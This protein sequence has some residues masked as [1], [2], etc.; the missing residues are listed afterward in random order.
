GVY[1]GV[2]GSAI[3][4]V[5]AASLDHLTLSPATAAVVAGA[6]Q[7]YA[8]EGFDLYGNDLGD[9]TPSSALSIAPDGTCTN[10]SCTATHWGAHTVAHGPLDY[11]ALTPVAATVVAGGTQVYAVEGFDQYG[12][13]R[14]SLVSSTFLS[15]SGGTCSG[16][17]CMGMTAGNQTVTASSGG[18]TAT[19]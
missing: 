5:T 4:T 13:D 17:S 16:M 2:T 9:V 6:S 18:K 10:G 11:L 12:N 15:M 8:V 3:L 7:S 14:G 1:Q 19:A